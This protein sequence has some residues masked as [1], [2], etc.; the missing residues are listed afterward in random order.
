MITRVLKRLSRDWF[1]AGM[2][3]AVALASVAPGSGRGSGPLR[4]DAVANAGI[5]VVFFLHGVALSTERLRAGLSSWRLHLVVQGFTFGVF[6]LLFL[7]LRAAFGR[8]IPQDLL[9]GFLYLAALPSTISSSVAM[10]ALARG[11]VPAAVFDA[12]LSSLLGVFLTPLLVSVLAGRVGASLSLGDA[13][14][15]I[16]GLLVVPLLAGQ[17]ARPVLGAWFARHR[18][19][20]SVLD[21]GVILLLVYVSFSG[22]VRAGLWTEHGAG[23]IA[24]AA[25]GAGALLATVLF[26]TRRAAAWLGFSPEDEIA[27]VFCGSK[28]TLGSGVPMARLLFGAH[29]GLGVVVLPILFYHPL[30]L[31]VCSVLAERYA[32]RPEPAAR[33]EP[34]R[35]RADG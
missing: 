20:T 3:S 4:A 19:Y 10:T 9:L 22:S 2:L 23:T 8:W 15:K 33:A 6:P 11:N 5:F 1:L 27:A 12:T 34:A 17:A 35:A 29:P 21:R 31:L 16:A 18:R 28:K 25:I 32:R 13:I 14:L 7:L 30:Q 26:L 24:G